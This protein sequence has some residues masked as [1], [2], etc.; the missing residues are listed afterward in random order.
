MVYKS[1]IPLI[2][3]TL[4][5]TTLFENKIKKLIKQAKN[6]YLAKS[7]YKPLQNGDSKALYKYLCQN[8]ENASNII[9]DLDHLNQ[10]AKT[11]IIAKANML[12]T[13][14]KICFH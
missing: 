2:G 6:T 4:I 3:T 1:R 11:P 9:P 13:F 14:F 12:N 7:L 8:R 5:G 10:A